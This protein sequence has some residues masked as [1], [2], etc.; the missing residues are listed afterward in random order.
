MN[1]EYMK[2]LAAAI[3]ATEYKY[4]GD[5]ELS[6]DQWDAVNMLVEHA[7]QFAGITPVAYMHFYGQSY[8]LRS[9]P[10]APSD[11]TPDRVEPLYFI[12]VLEAKP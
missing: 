5:Y 3:K 1:K 4:F 8:S 12:P 6:A 2:R 10:D 9:V 7:K 11:H